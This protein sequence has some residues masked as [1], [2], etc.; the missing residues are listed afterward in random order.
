M[1]LFTSFQ[2]N[3]FLNKVIIFSEKWNYFVDF[4]LTVKCSFLRMDPLMLQKNLQEKPTRVI[5]IKIY[6]KKEL[7]LKVVPIKSFF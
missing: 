7:L 1:F 4:M 2:E 5:L 6:L 3:S